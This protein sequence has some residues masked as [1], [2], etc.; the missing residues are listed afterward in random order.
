MLGEVSGS[1]VDAVAGDEIEL[2]GKNESGG[3]LRRLFFKDEWEGFGC[4]SPWQY[5]LSHVIDND[6]A[7][8]KT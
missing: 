2:G 1:V 5:S 8:T 4:G 3:G 7:S 6:I